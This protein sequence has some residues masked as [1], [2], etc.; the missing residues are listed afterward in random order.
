MSPRAIPPPLA[1]QVKGSS[2]II[3]GIP[4]EAEISLS[5]S[6]NKAPPP[7][8]TMP[9]SAISAANSGGESSNAFRIALIIPCNYVE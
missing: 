4:V 2:A 5:T 9:L 1:T 8:N 3:T 7:V 6:L